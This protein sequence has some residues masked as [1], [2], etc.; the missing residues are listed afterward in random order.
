MPSGVGGFL[1]WRQRFF[2]CVANNLFFFLRRKKK[3]EKE[4]PLRGLR[5]EVRFIMSPPGKRRHN[6][7]NAAPPPETPKERASRERQPTEILYTAE[8]V[9]VFGA[10]RVCSASRAARFRLCLPLGGE[11]YSV[12]GRTFNNLNFDLSAL[13]DLY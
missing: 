3:R 7:L 4:R 8:K 9:S 5:R 1:I 12:R 2:D 13:C 11:G 10:K 6:E